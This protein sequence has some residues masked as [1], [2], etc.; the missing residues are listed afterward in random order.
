MVI[1]LRRKVTLASGY[2]RESE[3][4]QTIKYNKFKILY[5]ILMKIYIFA[6]KK[7]LLLEQ[8]YKYTDAYQI[9]FIKT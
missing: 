8:K 7:I 3:N 5:T 1:L 4:H 2:K 6:E 9:N